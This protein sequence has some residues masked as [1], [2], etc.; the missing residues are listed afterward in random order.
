MSFAQVCDGLQRTEA[1]IAGGLVVISIRCGLWWGRWERQ[2]KVLGNAIEELDS[3]RQ[4]WLPGSL[5]CGRE[6]LKMS[7]CPTGDIMYSSIHKWWGTIGCHTSAAGLFQF[8]CAGT[9]LEQEIRYQCLVDHDSDKPQDSVGL[10]TRAKS[11]QR[12]IWSGTMAM[13]LK[14]AFLLLSV[15]LFQYIFH[16]CGYPSP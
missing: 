12:G 10:L 7:E 13:F 8:I 11:W 1:M 14:R 3:L 16:T 6:A 15:F 9:F 2:E 4:E 5:G